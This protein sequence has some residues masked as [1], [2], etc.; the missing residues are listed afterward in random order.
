MPYGKYFERLFT[1]T[2]DTRQPSL[3]LNYFVQ[4]DGVFPY[5]GDG[6]G[7]LA[8][9]VRLSGYNFETGNDA[10]GELFA[11]AQNSLL[12]SLYGTIYGGDA[13]TTFGMPDLEGRIAVGEGTG[14]GLSQTRLGE[15]TGIEDVLL[16]PQSLP[17]SLGGVQTAITNEQPSLGMNYIVRLNGVFPSGGVSEHG[18][19]GQVALF[20]GNRAPEGWAFA[21]GQLLDIASNS[22]LFSLL[23]TAFGGDG[24]TTFALPDLRG[25]AAVGEGQDYEPSL[26][27]KFY[28]VV[29]GTFPSRERPLGNELALGEIV[30]FAGINRIDRNVFE[31]DGQLLPISQYSALFSLYGTAFG[32]DGRTTFALPDLRGRSPMDFGTGPGLDTIAWGQKVGTPSVVLDVSDLP[33]TVTD[34]QL[35][36][37]TASESDETVITVTLTLSRAVSGDQVVALNVSGPGV[38]TADFTIASTNITILNGQSTATATLT[39]TDDL[40]FDGLETATVSVTAVSSGVRALAAATKTFTIADDDAAPV[41]VNVEDAGETSE[42][43]SDSALSPG[44]NMLVTWSQGATGV[45]PTVLMRLMD[46]DG[47]ALTPELAPRVASSVIVSEPSVFAI[48]DT[49][50]VVTHLQTVFDPGLFRFTTT[51]WIEKITYD[52]SAGTLSSSDYRA[53]TTPGADA[54]APISFALLDNGNVL[55]TYGQQTNAGSSGNLDYFAV[56]LDSDLNAVGNGPVRVDASMGDIRNVQ[57]VETDAGL[58]MIYGEYSGSSSN[59]KII[60]ASITVDA[61]NNITVTSRDDL[62]ADDTDFGF[63]FL[64]A[65]TLANGDILVVYNGSYSLTDGA[66]NDSQRLFGQVFD[67][68]LSVVKSEFRID[69]Q[70]R[71]QGTVDVDAVAFDGGGFAVFYGQ[72][73]ENFGSSQDIEIFVQRYDNTYAADG[74]VQRVTDTGSTISNTGTTA[75]VINDEGDMTIVW[76]SGVNLNADIA[77]FKRVLQDQEPNPERA[78]NLSVSAAA[79]TEADGTVITVTVTSTGAVNGAQTVDVAV[80]GTDITAGDFTLSASTVTIADGATTGSVTFTVTDDA[81]VEALETAVVTMSNPSAGIVLGTT[82]SQ[83]IQI[84]SDDLP[85]LTVTLNQTSVVEGGMVT[86]TVTR[87]GDTAAALTVAL[88]SDDTS[89]AVVPLSVTIPAGQT[90]VDFT[91]SAADDS[92]IDGTQSATISATATGFDAGSAVLGVSDNDPDLTGAPRLTAAEDTKSNFDLSGMT[93]SDPDSPSVTLTLKPGLASFDTPVSSG[94]VTATLVD[95]TTVTLTPSK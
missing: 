71:M 54:G 8:G 27:L 49:E 35:S 4:S 86:G 66:M 55:M 75:H 58:A 29:N 1:V 12:F 64:D 3:G 17:T 5:S 78:V 88:A 7:N 52:P 25:R 61:T 32:G 9:L 44:G 60:A 36:T 91:V 10:D 63:T 41:Q 50:F 38:S 51:L 34:V 74:A 15:K 2:L 87:E 85:A 57:L 81:L 48:S 14:S 92:T 56:V 45:N 76:H 31:A 37:A 22:A 28:V 40:A 69:H 59:T 53:V 65:V 43:A 82:T 18:F 62:I 23:G 47:T 33:P 95:A 68:T 24:R 26:G 46:A 30:A 89:E 16:S 93:F 39:I 84:T 20:G 21:H 42:L 67:G 73:E 80:T 94:G 13:R 19:M 83:T 77:I 70:D 6:S 90:S 72:R 79:G 11:I